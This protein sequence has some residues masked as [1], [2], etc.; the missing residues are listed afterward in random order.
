MRNL[1]TGLI[2][3]LAGCASAPLVVSLDSWRLTADDLC[4]LKVGERYVSP[5]QHAKDLKRLMPNAKIVQIKASSNMP[6]RCIGG[7]IYEMQRAGIKNVKF[8]VAK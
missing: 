8:E 6:Y 4:E 3:L 2:L 5:S 7:L 1:E